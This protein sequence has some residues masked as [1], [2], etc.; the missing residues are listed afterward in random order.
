MTEMNELSNQAALQVMSAKEKAR[1]AK[2]EANMYKQKA[3]KSEAIKDEALRK[4]EELEQSKNRALKSAAAAKEVCL[5]NIYIY[6]LC[7]VS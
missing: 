6:V 2:E 3:I 5:I 7:C 1:H 4:C